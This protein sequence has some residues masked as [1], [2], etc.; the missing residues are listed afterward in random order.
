[1]STTPKDYRNSHIAKGEDYDSNLSQG[2]FD[3]YMTSREYALLDRIIR[4]LFNNSIPRYLDFACGT[5]RIT[6]H[7]GGK[8]AKSYG[9]DLSS[10][11]LDVARKKCPDTEFILQ[12][13]TNDPLDIEPVDLVT[14]FRFFG[15]AQNDLRKQALSVLSG[16]VKPGGYLVFNNHRNPISISNLLLKARG[17][18]IDVDL[19]HK[20]MSRLLNDSGFSVKRTFGVGAWFVMHRLNTPRVMS[21]SIVKLIEPLSLLRPLGQFCPDAIIVAQKIK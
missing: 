19:S 17:N 12:D 8:T 6:S 4:D 14:A 16:L 21:S 5:G 9:V 7:I 18:D 10:N 13:I 2:D 20:K 11:M 15:N 3:T 1:M